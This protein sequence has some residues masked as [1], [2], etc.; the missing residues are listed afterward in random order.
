MR[1]FFFNILTL[2]PQTISPEGLV[3]CG[4]VWLAVWWVLIADVT[5]SGKSPAAKVFWVVVVTVPV[6]GGIIYSLKCLLTADWASAV[7]WR[8]QS[9]PK[10]G[11]KAAR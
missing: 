5:G 3:A 11:R 4:V 2:S 8:K 9:A 1:N 7:F 6:L 10:N